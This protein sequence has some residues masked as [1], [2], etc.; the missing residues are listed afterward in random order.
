MFLFTEKPRVRQKEKLTKLFE[1]GDFIYLSV[2]G[3]KSL[4]LSWGLRVCVCLSG[5]FVL[6]TANI[7]SSLSPRKILKDTEGSYKV[8]M[9]LGCM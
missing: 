2:S 3:K 9:G 1:L 4:E 8:F 5:R 6:F 7:K